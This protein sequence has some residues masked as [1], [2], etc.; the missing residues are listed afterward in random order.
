MI[1]HGLVFSGLDAILPENQNFGGLHQAAF[2][3]NHLTP[4]IIQVTIFHDHVGI[5]RLT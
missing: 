1:I 3:V 2:S 5:R 4:V